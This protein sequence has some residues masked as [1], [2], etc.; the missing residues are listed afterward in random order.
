MS[1][2][3]AEQ[4][5]LNL[6]IALSTTRHRLTREQ[7]RDRVDGYDALPPGA[8]EQER[9]RA[10][11]SFQRKF[12]RDKDEL[13]RLGLPLRTVTDPVNGNDL[14][15]RIDGDAAMPELD[16]TVHD[17]AIL[18]LAVEYWEGKSMAADARHG[19]SKL[20][21]TVEHATGPRLPF[22]GMTTSS[23]AQA[24]AL[25][26]QAVS[27]RQAV[28]FEYA[29]AS[30]AT[31]VRHVQPWG[32]VMQAGQEYLVGWD[33]D[34]EASRVFRLGRV[35]GDVTLV[36]EPDAFERPTAVPLGALS[37]QTPL[38]RAVVA[39]RPEAGHGFRRRGTPAGSRDGW[40]LFSVEYRHEDL[41]RAEVLATHGGARVVEP[42]A[43]AESVVA[44]AKAAKAV[45][46]G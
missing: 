9:Q 36:G 33:V 41:L 23:G 5:R 46:R 35:L 25:L 39:V 18:A 30:S 31:R 10:E 34:A 8:S 3:S 28:R 1:A 21:S 24:T 22:G 16:L 19:Y 42:I 26:S 13:R 45:T 2:T 4:R 38:S 20:I 44:H 6:M 17:A 29:S 7:I 14:G 40:E 43:L 32:I 37:T 12:E 27:E 15:Y 11:A